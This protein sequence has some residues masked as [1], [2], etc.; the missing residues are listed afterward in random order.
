M[1]V[2]L[3]V[4]ALTASGHVIRCSGVRWLAEPGQT[5]RAGQLIAYFNIEL[6][7]NDGDAVLPSAFASERELY[8]ACAPRV[9]GRL[10]FDPDDDPGG[11]LSILGFN[12]WAPDVALCE[13]EPD[14][15]SASAGDPEE[16]R[17]LMLAG[18]RMT[19][20][21][22]V[23]QGLFSGWHGQRR[24]WWS[25]G[26]TPLSVLNLGICDLTGPVIGE[27]GDFQEL[28]AD[29]KDARHVVFVP[30]HPIAPTAPVLLDQL[31]RTPAQFRAIAADLHAGLA[32][33][34]ATL[35]ADDWL[36]AGTLL[37]TMERNPIRDRHDVLSC[38]GLVSS[39]PPQNVVL[40]L[41]AESPAV[42]R[43]KTLGY[44]LNVMAHHLSA[45]GPAARR[46]IETSFEPV[47]RTTSDVKAD[48]EALIDAIGDATGAHVVV[49]NVMSTSGQEDI[50]TYAPFDAP[51]SAT[52]ATVAAKELNLMLHDVAATRSVTIVD[53]DALAAELGAAEHLPDGVHQSRAM[54]SAIRGELLH[55]LRDRRVERA[56]GTNGYVTAN[57]TGIGAAAAASA[58]I[59]SPA[60][61]LK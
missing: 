27:H 23:R 18:R 26:D 45:A 59:A 60:S 37:S 61:E 31:Q 8:V 33:S 24:A 6:Y 11:Y 46:W 50:S 39:D 21:A 19:D 2:P 32:K 13:I 49:L 51:M 3:R 57:S 55:A 56:A 54:Q 7:A 35:A 29:E 43:H 5:V 34:A 25:D 30:D 17:L 58:G 38:T 52:L 53:V 48:Y 40:S 41:S 14:G 20:L 10:V 28:F 12:V 47:R 1:R 9:G 16:L 15:A 22:D 42:L 4:G 44:R 36:F